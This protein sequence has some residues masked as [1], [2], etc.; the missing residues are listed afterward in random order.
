MSRSTIGD[1]FFFAITFF[2]AISSLRNAVLRSDTRIQDHG[3]PEASEPTL[4]WMSSQI[5]MIWLA[6]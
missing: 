4:S 2:F 5:E 6:S 3:W 1:Y